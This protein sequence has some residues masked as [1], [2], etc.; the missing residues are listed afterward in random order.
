MSRSPERGCFAS[1]CAQHAPSR[2]G[3]SPE[4]PECSWFPPHQV[5]KDV[6]E[7]IWRDFKAREPDAGRFEVGQ[8]RRNTGAL[9]LRIIS[10]DELASAFGESQPIGVELGRNGLEPVM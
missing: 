2:N 10:V 3:R 7:R 1:A 8:Q 6:L 9:A 4:L 5:D